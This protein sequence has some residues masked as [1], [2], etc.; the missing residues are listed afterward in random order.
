MRALD[1]VNVMVMMFISDDIDTEM[2]EGNRR[3]FIE[4]DGKGGRKVERGG[5]E[6]TGRRRMKLG[7]VGST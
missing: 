6:G 4:V 7:K 5:S 3:L 1:M 2:V